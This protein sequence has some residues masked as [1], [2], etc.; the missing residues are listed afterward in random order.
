[1]LK[2]NLYDVFF[3]KED[4]ELMHAYVLR[5]LEE[6]G[7][8]FEDEEAL[9][10]FRKHGAKLEGDIVYISESMVNDALK[11]IPESFTIKG[12]ENDLE[13]GIG[14]DFIIAPTNGCPT[15][16]DWDGKIRP[17][18]SD[19]LE[20]FYKLLNT[21]PV[22]DISSQVSA[23]IPGFENS[24]TESAMAQMAFL[25]KYSRKP[26]YN[27]LGITPHNYKC[28]SAKEG[29]K[30]T[31]Q[32]IKQLYDNFDDYV[33]YSGMCVLPPLTVGW[34]AIG[35]YIGY[36][37]E[38]Q[39]ITITTCSMS[40][41]T[42]PP[43]LMGSIV[44][45]YA[46]MLAV[47]IMIQLIEPGL[48]VILSPFSSI[49]DLREVRL[50]TGAP[51]FMLIMLGHLALGSYHRIPV[52]CS[53]SLADGFTYDYQAGVES[54]LGALAIALSDGCILPHAAGDLSNFNL[55]SF[56]KFMMDEE[57]LRY[58]RRLR[59]GVAVSDKKSNF[60]L[61]KKIGPRG[62]YL[63]G[64]TSKDYR[65]ETYLTTPVFNRS[66]CTPTD[67]EKVKD[68]RERSYNVFKERIESYELPDFDKRQKDL[69]NKHLPDKYKF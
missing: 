29:A 1:M 10:I 35:H 46:N 60:N 14:K 65:E 22:W 8:K 68:I 11:T 31:V 67:I 32:L 2:G 7:V 59:Q 56:P 38:K 33:C 54:T 13:I 34:D 24:P 63:S 61:I 43:S 26:I 18:N 64:R 20:N 42:A 58:M 69:L 28:G 27:I 50:M 5:T 30:A 51:E 12:Y 47:A 19:D 37:E 6:V 16:E 57:M 49:T 44:A 66:G 48:P 55:L 15:L 45:D 53:G 41:L 23:D 40:H 3:S 9:E 17:L 21:D 36:A 39:P 62:N 52:R 4:V 25:G